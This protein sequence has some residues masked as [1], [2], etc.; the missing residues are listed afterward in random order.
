[1]SEQGHKADE[2]ITKQ[3]LFACDEFLTKLLAQSH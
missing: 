3:Q 2:F 1:M